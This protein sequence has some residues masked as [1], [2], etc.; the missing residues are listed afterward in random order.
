MVTIVDE[1]ADHIAA[2]E[3][4]LDRAFGPGRQLKTSERL[5]QGRVP[6][7]GLS[8]AARDGDALVG[9]VRL[10]H[11]TAGRDCPALLLGPLAVE[12]G[13]Q[14]D[15]LGGQLMRAALARAA[16]AGHR[17][18]LLVGD[19]PYY[20]RFG[21]SAER[22]GYLRLPGPYQRQRLLGRE[23]VA[24]A[25]AAAQG[26]VV[27]TGAFEPAPDPVALVAAAAAA[28]DRRLARAA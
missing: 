23:L 10:W 24:G 22:T 5:R 2:R 12:P 26:L 18:V 16:A 7:R 15:G 11:V 13:R 4:L 1:T 27:A 21:F 19:A 3:A 17:A 14:G 6:A 20:G 28:R 8:L 9:T 25:L